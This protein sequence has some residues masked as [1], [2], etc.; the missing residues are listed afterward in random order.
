MHARGMKKIDAATSM[1]MF[2]TDTERVMRGLALVPRVWDYTDC[3]V[4]DSM[5][6]TVMTGV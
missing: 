3:I 6:A 2:F 1:A 4:G 5:T